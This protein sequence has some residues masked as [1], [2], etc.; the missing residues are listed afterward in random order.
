MFKYG[1][2]IELIK[3]FNFIADNNEPND[4]S[5]PSIDKA[6]PPANNIEVQ[7]KIPLT[8]E[9]VKNLLKDKKYSI[10]E[11]EK[12]KSKN[13]SPV[14]L[15]IRCVLD[16]NRNLVNKFFFCTICS[17]IIINECSTTTPFIRHVTVCMKNKNQMTITQFVKSP[18]VEQMKETVKIATHHQQKV[19]DGMIKFICSDI[20]PFSAV[21]GKGFVAA[22]CAGIE[23]GQ[24][25]PNLKPSE[26]NK[27]LPSRSTVQREIENKV[28]LAKKKV[29]A[30]LQ[31]AYRVFGG[32]SCTSDLWS[33]DYRQKSYI[34]VTANVPLLGEN[35]IKFERYIIGV[36][37]VKEAVKTKEVIESHI[38][39]MLLSYGFSESDVK[40][41]IYF[42]TDRGSNFKSTDKFKRA[43]CF[44]HMLHNIVKA[45]CKDNELVEI[46]TNAKD[47]VR[48]IKKGGLNYRYDLRLKSYC[49]TRWSTVY[50]MLNSI[51]LKFDDVYKILEDRQKQ[52]K[53]YSDCLKYIE[54]LHK[55][56]LSAIVEFL[57]PFKVWTDLVE[58]DKCITI[59]RVSPIHYKITNYLK[60]AM[61][62]DP[63]V[64]TS[65]KFKLIEGV[66][67][68]GREY[69]R[70]TLKSDFDPTMEQNIA[71][72]LHSRMKKLKKMSPDTREKIYTKLNEII[73][74]DVNPVTVTKE[75]KQKRQSQNLFDSFV[76]SDEEETENSSG[77]ICKELSDY[78]RMPITED[79]RDD[80]TVQSE[81]WFKHRTIFPNLFKIFMRISSIPA[82]SASSERPVK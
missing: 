63:K 77:N 41:S 55:S 56:T 5:N 34:T 29:K 10:G 25:Y 15:N 78:L 16:E 11:V 38:L 43:N 33:D 39:G 14:W 51:V 18:A 37:E 6:S 35:E 82:S 66:K 19:R 45:M 72:A 54:C 59:H 67:S 42:V 74:G 65:R 61:E 26:F 44:A 60:T 23:L 36:E 22:M 46:I 32:F 40:S 9:S 64:L 52:N 27:V 79:N 30:K 57:E 17:D 4:E 81:W 20:R 49:E 1:I 50:T 48:Y 47:L 69:I 53:R 58:A 3:E 12:R 13:T 2:F 8:K 21:E 62:S 71:V 28:D 24:A 31:E 73:S 7:P 76:D 68:L 80:S 70:S 75:I